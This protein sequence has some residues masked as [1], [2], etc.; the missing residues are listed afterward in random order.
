MTAARTFTA[1]AVASKDSL[2]V[3]PGELAAVIAAE[4]ARVEADMAAAGMRRSGP[5]RYSSR[6]AAGD[7][8]TTPH[9]WRRSV[10][11]LRVYASARVVRIECTG[12]A[13]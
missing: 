1:T 11:G 7:D 6:W 4:K 3:N 9:S 12:V 5:W 2:T 10:G 8:S 13:K